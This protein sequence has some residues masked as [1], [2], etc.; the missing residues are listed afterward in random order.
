[1]SNIKKKNGT[2]KKKYKDEP[3]YKVTLG[4]EGAFKDLYA[5]STNQMVKE[6]TSKARSFVK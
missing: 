2:L 3:R 5:S 6:I 1:M 4:Y